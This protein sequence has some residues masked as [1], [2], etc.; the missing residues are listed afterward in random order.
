MY[1]KIALVRGNA[2]PLLQCLSNVSDLQ[3]P[4]L[5]P[6]TSTIEDI[7]VT[8]GNTP[9]RPTADGLVPDWRPSMDERCRMIWHVR[10]CKRIL[11]M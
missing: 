7:C 3:H 2:D 9:F 10:E 8:D 4:D 1:L 5:D 11:I 6:I